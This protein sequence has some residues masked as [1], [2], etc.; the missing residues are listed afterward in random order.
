MS[1]AELQKVKKD[2]EEHARLPGWYL[3]WWRS[4]PSVLVEQSFQRW[5]NEA[6]CKLER[7]NRMAGKKKKPQYGGEWKG[8]VDVKLTPQEKEQFLAW[9]V[10]DGDVWTG[11]A[12]MGEA[13][14]KLSATYNKGNDN[15]TASYTCN[16][17]GSA[18]A[19]YTV[20]AHAKDIY[21]AC[22]L[23]LFKTGVVLPPDWTDYEVPE[24]EN[25]G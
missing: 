20:N 21:T 18:N 3:A 16:D 12:S 6:A 11:L 5:A 1:E 19:G 24:S 4:S 15:W 2:F 17:A 23:L 9:D 14:Y 10:Q 22:R 8:F 13:A 7:Y 25:F